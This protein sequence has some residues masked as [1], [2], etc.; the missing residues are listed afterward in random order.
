MY[1]WSYI[2]SWLVTVIFANIL[3]VSGTEPEIDQLD[4]ALKIIDVQI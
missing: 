4:G 3:R 2:F 1:M